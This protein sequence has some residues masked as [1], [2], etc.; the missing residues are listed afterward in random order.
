MRVRRLT[1]VSLLPILSGSKT[2]SIMAL[3]SEG[4]NYG[5]TFVCCYIFGGNWSRVR[6]QDRCRRSGEQSSFHEWC[7]RQSRS[8]RAKGQRCQ[9]QYGRARCEPQRFVSKKDSLGR[10]GS[11]LPALSTANTLPSIPAQ[12]SDVTQTKNVV[13]GNMAAR[14]VNDLRGSVTNLVIQA[15][16]ITELGRLYRRLAEE[17]EG[18][19]VLT[20][21]IRQLEI[22]TRQVQDEAVAGLEAKLS[23]AG[24]NGELDM[25][26]AMKEAVFADIRENLFSPTYQRIAATLM[27]K[28]HEAFRT[29]VSPLIEAQAANSV[30]DAAV[31]KYVVEPVV[32]E[33]DGCADFYDAP[34]QL[35]RGM[36]YFL[37]G[38]CHVRWA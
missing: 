22:Y 31:S 37:T 33:L 3:G 35:V 11:G 10:P 28:I 16:P 19:K 8:G 2:S 9:R 24:R 20:G 17:V 1:E 15:P 36:L 18:D 32:L 21:Y 27:G 13:M 34:V 14:D 26:M 7:A 30:V 5:A 29:H 12:P 23:A 4:G 38:N 6:T 25:A